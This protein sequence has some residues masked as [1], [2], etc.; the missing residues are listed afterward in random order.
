LGGEWGLSQKRWRSQG[1]SATP[2]RV[3]VRVSRSRE[4]V[5]GAIELGRDRIQGGL[6]ELPQVGTLGQVLA[7]QAVGVLVGAALPRAAR[8]TEVDLDAGVDGELGV[9]G[10]LPAVIPG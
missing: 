8:V 6:V 3:P 9:L 10:H 5:E 1:V 2:P 7:E 4:F